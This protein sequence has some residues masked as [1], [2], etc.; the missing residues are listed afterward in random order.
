MPSAAG[1]CDSARILVGNNSPTQLGCSPWIPLSFSQRRNQVFVQWDSALGGDIS[2]S[3]QSNPLVAHYY[4]VT[5]ATLRRKD[6]STNYDIEV[7]IV[8]AIFSI[9]QCVHELNRT[10][11][12]LSKILD[13]GR[14][15]D[16]TRRNGEANPQMFLPLATARNCFLLGVLQ[17]PVHTLQLKDASSSR[18]VRL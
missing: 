5:R 17:V 3:W 15:S 7:K 2:N 4:S 12:N 8:W 16:R 18:S 10:V 14:K 9:H 13:G 6:T 11:L 1:P